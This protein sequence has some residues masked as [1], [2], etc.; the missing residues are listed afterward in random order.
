[1]LAAPS[2]RFIFGKLP[3]Y[4]VLIV[5]GILLA[6]LHCMREEKRLGLKKDT[7][8]DLALWAIPF[9]VIGARLYYVI[10]AWDTFAANPLSAL[11]IWEGGLAIYGGVLGGLLGVLLFARRRRLHPGMLTDMIV[12]GLALAQAV[13]RWGNY[14]NM[15]AYGAAITDPRWQF[16]PAGVLIPENGEM[17]WHMAT[18]FYESM[19]DFAVFAVLMALRKRVRRPGDLTC[20]YLIL[21][22]LGRMVIEGLRTDSLMWGPVRVSQA[23]SLALCLGAA[24]VLIV[25]A[26]RAHPKTKREV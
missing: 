1:M 18:F 14:F 22:G 16:F 20:V 2:S 9:G 13:G 15:E 23:L 21:Y 12:P 3:W 4:S 10:F 5:S 26:L 17:V 11:K 7:V 24:A 8:T 19:W 6:L 25:R